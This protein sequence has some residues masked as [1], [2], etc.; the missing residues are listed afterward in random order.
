MNVIKPLRQLLVLRRRRQERFE[1]EVRTQTLRLR[2]AEQQVDRACADE[3]ACTG[4][5][6]ASNDKR[7][8]VTEFSFAPADLIM[9][10]FEVKAA[11][12]STQAAAAVHAKARTA[13]TTQLDVLAGC[14]AQAARNLQRI[15]DL[16]ERLAKALRE[17]EALEEESD[18]EESEE[19]AAAR[20]AG[21]RAAR[22]E[23]RR[24]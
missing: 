11:A 20:I 12:A 15:D 13:V 4:R 23:A 14:K 18:A 17:R 24:A 10:E 5:E 22:E 8:H 1:T 3:A 19:T 6:Q 2:E 7:R 21:R 16:K 9:A